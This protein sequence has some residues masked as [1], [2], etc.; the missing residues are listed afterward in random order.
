MMS[1]GAELSTVKLTLVVA[2]GAGLAAS[3]VAVP[4]AMLTPSVPSPVMPLTRT[5]GVAVVPLSTLTLPDAVPDAIKETSS[6]SRF[7]TLAPV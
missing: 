2:P 7:I 4:A 3:S 5:V 1:A 6:A